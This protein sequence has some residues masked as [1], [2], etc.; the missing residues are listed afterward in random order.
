MIKVDWKVYNQLA[1][2]LIQ[3]RKIEGE[4]DDPINSHRYP[5]VY[6]LATNGEK[7]IDK[8]IRIKKTNTRSGDKCHRMSN[9]SARE[10]IKACVDLMKKG[11][12]VMGLARIG[13]F[14]REAGWGHNDGP[15]IPELR[16]MNKD[17]IFM[18]VEPSGISVKGGFKI[19]YRNKDV[20]K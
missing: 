2:A 14:H 4:H 11:Y 5:W 9:I 13:N 19:V 1:R 3:H 12:V 16:S 8:T 10:M 6:L 15:V 18:T 17:A 20:G 7:T